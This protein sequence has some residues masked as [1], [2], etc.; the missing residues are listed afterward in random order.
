MGGSGCWDESPWGGGRWGIQQHSNQ[1]AT[2]WVEGLGTGSFHEFAPHAGRVCHEG[3][4]P[5]REASE[6]SQCWLCLCVLWV[7]SATLQTRPT[8]MASSHTVTSWVS[9]L[10]PW[11]QNHLPVGGFTS[12]SLP[13]MQG[14]PAWMLG[15]LDRE[16]AGRCLEVIAV[17]RDP[18]LGYLTIHVTNSGMCHLFLPPG[19]REAEVE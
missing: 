5:R 14:S 11:A 15:L 19:L 7:S 6:S 10:G 17:V 1:R 3:L 18:V 16:G 13:Q 12:H 4:M 8:N 9:P 2:A